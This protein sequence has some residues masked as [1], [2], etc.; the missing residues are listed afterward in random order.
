VEPEDFV[1]QYRDRAALRF[2]LIK[3]ELSQ[4]FPWYL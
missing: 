3:G 2:L 1:S 4:F